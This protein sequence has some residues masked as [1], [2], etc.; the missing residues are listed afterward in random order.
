MAT[1]LQLDDELIKKAVTLGA[2][3]TKRDAV[4]KALEDYVGRLE[5]LEIINHFGTFDFDPTY[6]Y[7]KE[8]SKR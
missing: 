7:K 8:R 3:K 2:H 5:R 1:N 4:T 6:D